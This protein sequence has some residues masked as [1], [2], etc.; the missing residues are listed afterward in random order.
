MGMLVA[1][2]EK[3]ERD[4]GKD[5]MFLDGGSAIVT[6]RFDRFKRR[7]MSGYSRR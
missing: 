6:N 4:E 5:S 7:T 2:A 1:K 3:R